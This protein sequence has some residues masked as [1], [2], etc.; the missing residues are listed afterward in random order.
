MRFLF[1]IQRDWHWQYK[2]QSIN[3]SCV[4]FVENAS[5]IKVLGV[6]RMTFFLFVFFVNSYLSS[7]QHKV[8]AGLF[9]NSSKVFFFQSQNRVIGF[10]LTVLMKRQGLMMA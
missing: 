1:Y 9:N 4:E 10:E 3:V 6:I 2:A 5:V 7:L 8:S